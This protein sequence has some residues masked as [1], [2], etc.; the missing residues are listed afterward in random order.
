MAV[1]VFTALTTDTTTTR[2]TSFQALE[3]VAVWPLLVTGL[4]CLASGVL[5]GLGDKYGL[6]RIRAASPS[7]EV[8]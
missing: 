3:L 8:R 7:K 4:V 6:V 1:L 5:L 2:A